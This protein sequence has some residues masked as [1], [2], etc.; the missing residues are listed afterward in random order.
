MLALYQESQ[1]VDPL[2][3]TEHL[4]SR[5]ELE[6]A[7]GQAEVDALTG[8]V[9]AVGN[10]RATRASCA[11]TRCCAACCQDLRDPDGVLN[12]TSAPRRSSSW[13]SA[14][15]SRSPTTT[16]RRT[17]AQVGEVLDVEIDK[18]QKLSREGISLTG[19]PSGFGDLDEITGGFQP[20]N[21]IILAARPSMGKCLAARHADP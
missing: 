10:A 7:G 1:P 14:A 19:T 17:S 16:A 21:L 3:V 18:W 12:R 13:P 6:H 8:A 9:P 15:S 20:G 5:G 11:S 4:R 2:T